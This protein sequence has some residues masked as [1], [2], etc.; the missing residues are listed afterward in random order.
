[1]AN[2]ILD[3][4][5][6]IDSKLQ[7][8]ELDAGAL[9]YAIDTQN[10]YI[11]A[12]KQNKE[13]VERQ[14]INADKAYALRDQ[15]EQ[16]VAKTGIGNL[17]FITG[18]NT[19]AMGIASQAF[20]KETIANSDSCLTI[21]EFNASDDNALFI[22]GNGKSNSN[23][24]NAFIVN[25]DGTIKILNSLNIGNVL[26]VPEIHYGD[27]IINLNAPDVDNHLV[28]KPGLI[29]QGNFQSENATILG[30]LTAA[31]LNAE[32]AT[33][34]TKLT[35]TE[36]NVTN[37][38]YFDEDVKIKGS[39]YINYNSE[40]GEYEKVV[41]ETYVTDKIEEVQEIIDNL[42]T[43]VWQAGSTAP[44]DTKLLWVRYNDAAAAAKGTDTYGYG[45]LY[46]FNPSANDW[47]PLSAIYT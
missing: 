41:S 31:N 33:I 13:T 11:D 2:N 16:I 4:R 8:A 46:Y 9:S 5:M 39:A 22:V 35:T 15:N 14:L 34:S 24:S 36:L 47:V 23:R 21:G 25:K 42:V 44:T 26:E 18:L 3:L 40:T 32:N 45:A 10:L 30:N 6:G 1:M 28:I 7:S 43:D 27:T 29:V 19:S 20:G 38:A 37:E 12:L 17:S